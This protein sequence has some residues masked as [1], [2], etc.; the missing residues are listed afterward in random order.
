MAARLSAYNST[1]PQELA[2]IQTGIFISPTPAISAFDASAWDWRHR[3]AIPN[4][5]VLFQQMGP[6]HTSIVLLGVKMIVAPSSFP[7][8]SLKS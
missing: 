1:A 6:F 3:V 7:K 2:L 5:A 8:K 4:G